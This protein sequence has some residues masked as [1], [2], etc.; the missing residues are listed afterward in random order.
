MSD[1]PDDESDPRPP[2]G[3]VRMRRGDGIFL[4]SFLAISAIGFAVPGLRDA[5]AAG[6]ALFGWWM[7]GLMVLVPLV[8][9]VRSLR[10]RPASPPEDEP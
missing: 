10:E 2:A 6:V 3:F 9:L 8:A 1:A 7:A 4:A 5:R